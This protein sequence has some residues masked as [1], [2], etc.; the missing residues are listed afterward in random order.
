M[1]PRQA[2]A[3]APLRRPRTD[4]LRRGLFGVEAHKSADSSRRRNAH[5][6]REEGG[7][8]RWR[9]VRSRRE[10]RRS[11]CRGFERALEGNEESDK[12]F[13]NDTPRRH[14]ALV[15][16]RCD[17]GEFG[18][19]RGGGRGSGHGGTPSPA[20]VLRGQSLKIDANGD[21]GGGAALYLLGARG[22]LVLKG[23]G[24]DIRPADAHRTWD[25]RLPIGFGGGIIAIGS[26][27]VLFSG[28]RGGSNGGGGR[29][30][31]D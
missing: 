19:R 10:R 17:C 28:E 14:V 15:H 11:N 4:R 2:A 23:L 5:C 24:V 12:L 26:T 30:V 18:W 22:H 8:W 21:G 16:S 20:T 1:A 27:P 25:R 13:R 29:A 3:E 6:R 7:E 31:L 9:R